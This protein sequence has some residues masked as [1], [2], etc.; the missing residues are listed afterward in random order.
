MSCCT[1]IITTFVNAEQTV[2]PFGDLQ[3]AIYGQVPNVKVLYLQDGEFIEATG[4]M[5]A[6]TL[7]ESQITVNHGGPAT[8]I[9][10]IN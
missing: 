1:P 7:D 10:K 8:G 4:F 3:K 5:T 2:I 6:I 9:I